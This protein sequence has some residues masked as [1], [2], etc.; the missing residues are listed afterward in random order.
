MIP[1]HRIPAHP[2]EVLVG[3]FLGPMKITQVGFAAHIGVP[4]QRIN[5][6]CRG[7]RGVT[8]E[9]AWQSGLAMAD[10]QLPTTLHELPLESRRDVYL[11]VRSRLGAQAPDL[12]LEAL[13][14]QQSTALA[15]QEATA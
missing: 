4:V 14:T 10:N 12:E 6:I 1:S 13:A 11:R 5:E 9:S 3:E 2:G 7:K 8:P 15:T